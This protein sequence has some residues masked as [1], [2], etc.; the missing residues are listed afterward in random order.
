MG[1]RSVDT[2]DVEIAKR[3]RALRL[4]RGLTQVEL[5]NFLGVTFQQFQKYE[6]GVNRVS[7]GRLQRIASVLDVP[8][9]FFFTG[10]HEQGTTNGSSDSEFDFFQKG[11]TLQMARA[12]SR[13]K[14]RSIRRTLLKLAEGIA[15]N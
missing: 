14:E 15:R 7:A 10:V 2:R 13:I 12:Y 11:D 4:E 1:R 5:G 8:V 6:R 9:T 3:I